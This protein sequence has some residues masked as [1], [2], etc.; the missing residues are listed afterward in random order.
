MITLLAAF[1]LAQAPGAQLDE[2]TLVVRRDT[3][4]VA[5]ET[6]RLL[7]RRRADS[8]AGWLLGTTVR[9]NTG[10][11]PEVLAPVIELA[12][13]SEPNNL[14]VDV[15]E[16]GA[17][18]RITGQP[19]PGRYTLRYIAPG[20]ERARELPLRPPGVLVMDSVFTPYL[21][22]AWRAGGGAAPRTVSAIYIR[23]P[24]GARLTVTD[25]GMGSTTLNR[26]LATLRHI[27]VRGGPEGPVHVWLAADGRLMKVEL[28]DRRLR[29]ERLPS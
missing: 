16:N 1:A 5:R 7:E 17:A 3:Q 25:L 18:L 9:W 8:A 27:V 29:A 6:F 20:L 14:A 12:S 4:E 22:A 10:L 24:R 2:G 13:D 21:F 15:S 23:A 28:P 19:G 26:D 11:R